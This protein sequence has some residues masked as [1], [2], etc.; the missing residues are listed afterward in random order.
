MEI[1]LIFHVKNDSQYAY[2]ITEPGLGQLSVRI[3]LEI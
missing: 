2:S 3:F 1:F